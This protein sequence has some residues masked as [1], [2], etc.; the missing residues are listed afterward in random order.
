MKQRSG[1]KEAPI[2][3]DI[4]LVI[5]D[6]IVRGD[7]AAGV[8]IKESRLADELGASRTPLR[9]ALIRL[10]QEGFVRSELAHGFSVEPLCGR[11][12]RE[13][14]PILWTLEAFAL[15]TSGNAILSLLGD[16]SEINVALAD[17][18][19]PQE[20]LTLDAA[21]HEKL[22]SNS[23][24]R[25]LAGIISK[26]RMSIRRYEHMYM[27]D[28]VLFLESARQHQQIIDALQA[29]QFDKAQ[30]VLEENWRDSMELLLLRLGEP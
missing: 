29:R 5:L 19:S 6:R 24:N 8:R 2:R 28:P 18:K 4:Y 12:V 23:P 11:E 3:A 15:R 14:Y 22:I 27:S 10:E 7:L 25:R 16:L 20:R 9:E 13:T 1:N 21:W 30:Q 17:A 26:L